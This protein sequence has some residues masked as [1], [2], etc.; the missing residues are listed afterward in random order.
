MNN[1]L[2]IVV[3]ILLSAFFSG[4]EIAFLSSNKLKIELEKGRG[5]LTAR[6][7]SSLYRDPS[8]LIGAMLLGNNMAL[9]IYGIAM[10]SV[11]DPFLQT[12]LPVKFQ[13]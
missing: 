12:S 1:T 13:S 8:R 4:M 7:M 9:V 3:T 2:A 6:I 11:L 10:A 5:L